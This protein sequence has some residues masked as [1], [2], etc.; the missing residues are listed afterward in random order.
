M[1]CRLKAG[2]QRENVHAL[3][4]STT[5]TGCPQIQTW[6]PSARHTYS[7]SSA[8]PNFDSR[9]R[10]AF[11]DSPSK[12]AAWLLLPLARR[13]ASRIILSSHCSRVIPSGRNWA[14]PEV[15]FLLG[16]VSS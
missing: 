11:L 12:R 4:Q 10:S 5:E 13:R 2:W 16:T 14:D 8:T 3:L 1:V 7:P 6:A 9:Y 15:W